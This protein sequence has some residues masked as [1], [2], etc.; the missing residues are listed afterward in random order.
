MVW[1]LKVGHKTPIGKRNVRMMERIRKLLAGL[2]PETQSLQLECWLECVFS[3]SM[4]AMFC[5]LCWGFQV[6]VVC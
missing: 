5:V 3:I 4:L 2:H 6:R 1:R